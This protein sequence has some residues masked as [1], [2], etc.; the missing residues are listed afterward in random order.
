MEVNM[1]DETLGALAEVGKGIFKI[2]AGVVKAAAKAVKAAG[3]TVV[4]LTIKRD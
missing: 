2:T 1:P 3:K 4:D